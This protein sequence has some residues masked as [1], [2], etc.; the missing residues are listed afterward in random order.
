MEMFDL[1]YVKF[2]IPHRDPMLL[3]R[4][5]DWTTQKFIVETFY[6][7]PSKNIFRWHI[8]K[9]PVFPGVYMV[10]RIT[11]AGDI[12]SYSA[13]RYAGKASLLP[14]GFA[15]KQSNPKGRHHVVPPFH[16]FP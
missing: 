12:L 10:E 8:P 3:V 16:I 15:L 5:K 2:V 14:D 4:Q 6:E 13:E 1:D 9:D 11:Y 7:D